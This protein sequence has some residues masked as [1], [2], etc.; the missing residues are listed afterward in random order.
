[1]VMVFSTDSKLSEVM[2]QVFYLGVLP[3]LSAPKHGEEPITCTGIAMTGIPTM[4]QLFNGTICLSSSSGAFSSMFS[5]V[6]SVDKET[7]VDTTT[8]VVIER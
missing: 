7:A 1:M 6:A 4:D 5:N 8:P 3:N 2:F